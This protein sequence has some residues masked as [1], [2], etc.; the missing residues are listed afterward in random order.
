[1]KFI[2][3]SEFIAFILMANAVIDIPISNEDTFV[4]PRQEGK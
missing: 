2:R 3:A 4:H 1:M